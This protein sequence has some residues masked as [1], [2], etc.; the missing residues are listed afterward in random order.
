MKLAKSLAAMEKAVE[1][2]RVEFSFAEKEHQSKGEKL[3][4]EVSHLNDVIGKQDAVIGDLQRALRMAQSELERWKAR[5]GEWAEERKM[6]LAQAEAK[7]S[8]WEIA[9]KRWE[10]EQRAKHEKELSEERASHEVARSQA[11]QVGADR[12]LRVGAEG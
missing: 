8:E 10:A 12:I 5:E 7:R 11:E 2:Q 4:G 1:Q 3:S 6:L 9:M